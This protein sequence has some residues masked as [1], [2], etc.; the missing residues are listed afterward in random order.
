MD[1]VASLVSYNNESRTY[2]VLTLKCKS[3]PP[4]LYNILAVSVDCPLTSP[5]HARLRLA[6]VVGFQTP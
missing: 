4:P 3:G 6:H 5:I 2:E 1:G